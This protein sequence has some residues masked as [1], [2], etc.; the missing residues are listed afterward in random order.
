MSAPS[1]HYR[2]KKKN[3][4]F[5]YLLVAANIKCWHVDYKKYGLI[6]TSQK[7]TLLKINNLFSY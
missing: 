6:F 2:C 3:H 5:V 1:F 4:V 7:K